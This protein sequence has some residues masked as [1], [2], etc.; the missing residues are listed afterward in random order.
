MFLSEEAFNKYSIFGKFENQIK[1]TVF[2]LENESKFEVI[3]FLNYCES[4]LFLL[5]FKLK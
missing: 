2:N 1:S 4:N 5:H 3:P